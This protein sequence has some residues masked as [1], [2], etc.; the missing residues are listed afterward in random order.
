M[1]ELARTAAPGAALVTGA[2]G[3]IGREVCLSLARAGHPV[4]AADRDEVSAAA[5][6]DLVRDLGVAAR[7]ATVD[8]TSSTAFEQ[9]VDLAEGSLGPIE[10]L[11]QVAGIEGVGASIT[12]YPEDDFDR[13]MAVNAKGTFLG[14]RAVLPRIIARGGGA[15]VN[16][17]S[18]LGLRG[19][20]G[21]AAYVASKHAV[22]GLT[23]T[24][25]IETARH[26]V[27]VNA[28]C[29]G[30][31]ETRMIQSIE[32]QL[33]PDRDERSDAFATNRPMD[34]Y[35]TPSEIAAVVAFL[36]GS[37]ASYVTGS[38]WTVDGGLSAL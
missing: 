11:V 28:V 35:S 1:R 33:H 10:L 27:R 36:C 29:P 4:V 38:A 18:G 22:V 8:V 9:I 30:P 20:A 14:M 2:G 25:A 13:V 24:A 12:A 19:A 37:G 31:V 5:T 17:A 15:V 26:H 34:R 7:P 23:K 3:G 21:L 16:V 6:A 32:D